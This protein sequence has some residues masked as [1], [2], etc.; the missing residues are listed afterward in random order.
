MRL[1]R[2]IALLVAA[3]IPAA[4]A[5]PYTAGK[6]VFNNMGPYTQDQLEATHTVDLVLTF[7]RG[8]VVAQ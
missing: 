6:I 4:A 2:V 3:A 7:V 8:G 5:A 1:L